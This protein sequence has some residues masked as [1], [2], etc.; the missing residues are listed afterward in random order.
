[1]CDE[2]TYLH[3]P[4]ASLGHALVVGDRSRR[5]CVSAH[6]GNDRCR[7]RESVALRDKAVV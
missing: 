1:M 3:N 2:Q 4:P 5:P 7:K 6:S